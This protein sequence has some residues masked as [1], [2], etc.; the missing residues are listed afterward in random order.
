MFRGKGNH[1]RVNNPEM[2]I[3]A[4]DMDETLGG[5]RI[6]KEDNQA[7]KCGGTSLFKGCSY[8]EWLKEIGSE[9]QSSQRCARAKAEEGG[10]GNQRK[11][12]ET[13]SNGAP[14]VS[15]YL[16]LSMGRKTGVASTP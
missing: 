16:Q 7:S 8:K 15:E 13:V 14:R 3:Q 6:R 1:L 2:I 10:L 9:T 5:Q 11:N 12:W 4:T